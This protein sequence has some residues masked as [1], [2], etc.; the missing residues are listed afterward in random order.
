MKQIDE[1]NKIHFETEQLINLILKTTNIKNEMKIKFESFEI[2]IYPHIKE[3]NVIDNNT[4]LSGYEKIG[5]L[6]RFLQEI[7][8]ELKSD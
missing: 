1:K 2:S 8:K 7:E 4:T 6:K 3:I 5:V